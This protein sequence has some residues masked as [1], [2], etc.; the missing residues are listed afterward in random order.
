MKEDSKEIEMAKTKFESDTKDLQLDLT[1][2][3][4]SFE[5]LVF[6]MK[7]LLSHIEP[8]EF[9]RKFRIVLEHDPEERNVHIKTYFNK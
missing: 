3:R 6:M 7:Q 8:S 1:I 9:G 4:N 2:H 5:M